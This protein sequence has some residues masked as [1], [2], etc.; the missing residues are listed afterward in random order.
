[1]VREVLANGSHL[2]L[3]H[4]VYLG[5]KMSIPVSKSVSVNEPVTRPSISHLNDA[6]PVVVS[7]S[8]AGS[9]RP[10]I[11]PSEGQMHVDI[12]TQ[13]P[14]MM[15][16]RV[17]DQQAFTELSDTLTDQIEQATSARSSLGELLR[18]IRQEKAEVLEATGRLQ[19]RLQVG[20]RL[21][22]ALSEQSAIIRRS[23]ADAQEAERSLSQ[24]AQQVTVSLSQVQKEVEAGLEQASSAAAGALT[25]T[26]HLAIEQ[27]DDAIERHCQDAAGKQSQLQELA[28]R[29]NGLEELMDSLERTIASL[30]FR[31]VETTLMAR[32]ESARALTTVAACEQAKQSL[33]SESDATLNRLQKLEARAQHAGQSLVNLTAEQQS[34]QQLMAEQL[35]QGEALVGSLAGAIEVNSQMRGDLQE[36]REALRP[37]ESWCDQTNRDS[38]DIPE[39]VQALVTHLKRELSSDVARVSMVLREVSGRLEQSITKP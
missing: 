29:C 35:D 34:H 5:A 2:N 32:E 14:V 3:D 24:T 19:D 36:L 23:G 17:L 9:L 6:N 28:T 12:D 37:W 1:M 4:I 26:T 25:E 39:P 18:D 8:P 11:S 22:K 31:T 33:V 27:L 13:A 30:S 15:T 20:A 7:V 16:P 10:D 21:L 38:N